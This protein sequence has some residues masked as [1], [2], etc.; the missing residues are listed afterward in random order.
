MWSQEED[1]MGYTPV[2]KHWAIGN[3]GLWS[4]KE[5]RKKWGYL[6][7]HL[8]FFLENIFLITMQGGGV[9]T[10]SSGLS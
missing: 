3:S 9:K 8:G 7:D 2:F 6:Y 5:E 10:E 4:Q 1:K